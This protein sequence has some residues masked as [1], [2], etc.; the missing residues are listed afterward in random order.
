M[1][2]SRQTLAT[3]RAAMV[4]AATRLF[5]GRGIDAVGVAEIT[6]A[7][8][9]THGAFYGHFASK[10]A[11]VAEAFQTSLRES[12]AKWR[13]RAEAAREAGTDPLTTLIERHLS[14]RHRDAPESGCALAALGSEMLRDAAMQDAVAAGIHSLAEVLHEEIARLYPDASQAAY[15]ATALAMLAAMN[16]GIVV[17]RALAHD[18]DRSSAVLRGVAQMV[19]AHA[20]S[21][22]STN[23]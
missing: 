20:D 18:P 7:A 16:G 22:H 11:L 1:R 8:G 17:A 12:A 23:A 21:L 14:E 13:Q 2:V 5:R 10:Q 15:E 4:G 19:R 3:H 9:M 6:A